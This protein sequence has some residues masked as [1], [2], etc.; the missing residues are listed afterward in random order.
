MNQ[1]EGNEQNSP[2]LGNQNECDEQ[3]EIVSADT[4]DLN[5]NTST[6]SSPFQNSDTATYSSDEISSDCGYSSASSIPNLHAVAKTRSRNRHSQLQPFDRHRCYLGRRRTRF[7][8]RLN[9]LVAMAGISMDQMQQTDDFVDAVNSSHTSVLSELFRNEELKSAWDKF[10]HL[11]D[12]DQLAILRWC[13][14]S[15]NR[16]TKDTHKIRLT[17]LPQTMNPRTFKLVIGFIL[18]GKLTS[19]AVEKYENS[20]LDFIRS[21]DSENNLE[22]SVQLESF[23]DQIAFMAICQH[24]NFEYRSTGNENRFKIVINNFSRDNNQ[25]KFISLIEERLKNEESKENQNISKNT[26]HNRLFSHIVNITE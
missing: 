11:P 26:L 15:N 25:M 18:N 8:E 10:I 23:A 13:K 17:P 2:S 12:D 5:N 1:S 19:A 24:Y 20:I 21:S 9:D 22:Y 14:D 16:R 4:N 3:N 7:I 6:T